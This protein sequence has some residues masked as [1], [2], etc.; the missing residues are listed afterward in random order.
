M[1][2]NE[3]PYFRSYIFIY[4]HFCIVASCVDGQIMIAK[5]FRDIYSDHRMRTGKSTT[6]N[7]ATP[8]F[9]PPNK[10]RRVNP[11]PLTKQILKKQIL[12]LLNPSFD[13]VFSSF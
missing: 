13:Y 5:L 4:G 12:Y 3:K 7:P 9:P 1:N 2:S 6:L 8:Y 10:T 11:R